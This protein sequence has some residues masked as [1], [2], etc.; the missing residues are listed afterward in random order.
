MLASTNLNAPILSLWL[1]QRRA[2]PARRSAPRLASAAL[3]LCLG[4]G[5]AQTQQRVATGQQPSE[6]SAA[7]SAQ[8]TKSSGQAAATLP[9]TPERPVEHTYH[10]DV[11]TDPYEWLE[12]P[13]S[14]EVQAWSRAQNRVA[15]AY[16]DGLPRRDALSARIREIL[17][18]PMRNYASLFQRGTRFFALER[19]PP[20]EQLRL[21][22]MDSLDRPDDARVLLDPGTLDAAG[23]VAIDWFRPSPDGS[24]VA[25]SLSR[26]GSERGDVH[27]YRVEDGEKL[28]DTIEYVNGGTAG[29]DLAWMPDGSGFFYTRYPREGE[30]PEAD[31]NFYQQLYFHRLGTSADD[32]RYELG[33]D[34]PR[35][36]EIQIEM[37]RSGRLLA[38]VQKGDGGE[39]AHYLRDPRGRWQQFSTFGDGLVQASFGPRNDLYIVSRAD[40][41]TGRLL[42]MPIRRRLNPARATEVIAA[43][44]QALVTDFW[45]SPTVVVTP[46]RIYAIYQTGGPSELRAFD[47]R[48]RPVALP[49]QPPV[50]AVSDLL[51]LAEGALLF[52][53]ESYVAPPRW[54]KLVPGAEGLVD[55]GLV[56]SSPV[57]SSGWQVRREMATSA[58]G[59]AVPLN[60]ILPPGVELD[61]DNPCVITG[62]GGYGVNIEPRFRALTALHMDHGVIYV[63]TNLRGGSEFGEAWHEA[64][65]LT[66]KQNVFDDFAAAI[67]HMV[68]RRYTRHDRIGIIGGSNGGLLMGAMLTQHPELVKVVVSYVGIYDMLRVELS[69]NG[70]FNVTEFGT[71]QDEAQY[72]A[73]AAYSPY[74]RVR[75]GVAYPATLF[76]T[77]ANDPR[78]EPWHSRKMTARLQAA[79]SGDAPILLRTSDTSGHGRD[80]SLSERIAETSDVLSFL[81]SQ[82]QVGQT[83][84]SA[85]AAG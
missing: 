78:V 11:V 84:P 32:D 37:H 53:L 20:A 39:F 52:R 57:D 4:C 67:R 28:D 10:G 51:P 74:H 33:R 46:Q 5:G 43:G 59:T 83:P 7:P 31:R 34:L 69:P 40:A 38:T 48:G 81:F 30:R 41:P 35:I 8:P 36:A 49:A 85:P 26:G 70:A 76:L 3:A 64:G 80:T 61:G 25:V 6:A 66:Q 1:P 79:Q 27:L 60:I 22:V 12:D 56:Q 17:A 23:H 82:L 65:R 75:P 42:R 13:A 62:Y 77:G 45:G 58:D 19:R 50:S 44:E 68:E 16:L 55:T 24:L 63:V 18:A 72:R 47:L 2:W 54:V 29:G 71:V 73:L 21:V 9:A 14:D 15:R